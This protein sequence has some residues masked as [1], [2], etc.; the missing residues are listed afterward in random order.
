MTTTQTDQA[1]TVV[2]GLWSVVR[3]SG[4]SYVN[5]SAKL[6]HA[7]RVFDPNWLSSLHLPVGEDKLDNQPVTLM[8]G[9]DFDR[10]AGSREEIKAAQAVRPRTRV[11]EN[12]GECNSG[13]IRSAE[14][15][16]AHQAGFSV[17]SSVFQSR[18]GDAAIG[19]HYD[20]WIGVIVQFE[21]AKVWDIW[22]QDGNTPAKL[23]TEAGDVLL[24]PSG[25]EHAVR[26]PEH[27]LH[28]N[29]EIFTNEP[30]ARCT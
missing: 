30:L 20:V 11:Y 29:F 5:P 16:L 19:R 10:R 15:R 3:R 12:F 21:G 18:A 25:V 22:Y 7:R 14:N 27:S 13:W 9:H 26:T 17:G 24:M 2:R 8:D 6:L 4:F 28:V 23:I 1:R